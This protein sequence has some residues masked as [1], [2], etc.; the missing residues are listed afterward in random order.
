MRAI[1]HRKMRKVWTCLVIIAILVSLCAC[2]AAQRPSGTV[3]VNEQSGSDS[4]HGTVTENS[5][6][7]ETAKQSKNEAALS[8]GDAGT[9]AEEFGDA[10]FDLGTTSGST[11]ENRFLGIG[12]TLDE[13]W[14]FVSEEELMASHAEMADRTDNETLKEVLSSTGILK[15][16]Y[17][18]A[19]N[20]LLTIGVSLENMGVLY[21]LTMDEDT[22]VDQ[23]LT[24]YAD[25]INQLGIFSDFSAE[26]STVMLAGQERTAIRSHGLRMVE[27]MDEGFEFYMVQA[28]IK[29][30]N[31]MAIIT[32][33]SYLE[34][35]T[36][37]L[38]SYFYA[39]N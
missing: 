38:A 32:L 14:T 9:D 37:T 4:P 22:Y 6:P 24:M 39:L 25:Q 15:D 19:D 11:Y 20:G 12:C 3:T 27:G 34:D 5:K 8:A 23:N 18:I 30:G 17:A 26:K 2:S 31:Y 13:N 7:E 33:G 29:A 36:D 1:P 16:M 10:E 28:A 21:G 35:V